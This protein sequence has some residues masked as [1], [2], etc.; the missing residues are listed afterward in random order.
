MDRKRISSMELL[1]R[2][3]QRELREYQEIEPE[4]MLFRASPEEAKIRAEEDAAEAEETERLKKVSSEMSRMF[5]WA[6]SLARSGREAVRFERW[7]EQNGKLDIAA[8]APHLRGA[9]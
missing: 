8:N 6:E 1:E 4:L 3:R 5:Q 7:R 2:T 9:K